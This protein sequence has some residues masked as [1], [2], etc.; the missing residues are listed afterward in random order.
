VFYS[1]VMNPLAE[2]VAWDLTGVSKPTS[3]PVIDDADPLV[4]TWVN[5]PAFA[6][7]IMV[8]AHYESEGSVGSISFFKKDFRRSTK[9]SWLFR[10]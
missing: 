5:D 9:A 3:T 7:F 1:Y 2:D 8:T 10:L 6:P 4:H